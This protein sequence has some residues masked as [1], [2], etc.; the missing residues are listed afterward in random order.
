[1]KR[2]TFITSAAATLACCGSGIKLKANEVGNLPIIFPEA[3]KKGDTIGVIAPGTAVTDPDDIGRA[4]EVLSYFGLKM[5]LGKYVSSGN[6]YKTRPIAQRLDDI[7]SFFEDKNI[8]GIFCIRG[9]YGC[10]RLLDKID[11]ELIRNNPKVFLGYSD[12]T[13]MHLAINK[14]SGLATFH[15]PVM[16]S[17]FTQFTADNMHRAI[18][19]AQPMGMLNNPDFKSNLR[20]SY[21]VR[22]IKGGKASGVLIGGNL[23]LIA[24]L[25]GTP[26]QIEAKDKILFLEDVSEEPFRIDRMLNQL[27]LGG[28]FNEVKGI[29]FGRCADCETK[30]SVWDLSLGEVLD[31]YFSVLD[32]PVIYGLMIGHTQDQ[33]TLPIGVRAELDAD[34]GTLF[35]AEQGVR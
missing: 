8:S 23:S 10:G 35:I 14:F 3:L 18:F 25:M 4:E 9:G 15:G 29:V 11:Y 20:S 24:S 22:K 33:L 12:I 5:K 28:I 16:L 2:R 32:I 19:S 26:Y 34:A 6:G 13:A 17:A 7:H 1:M 27:R 31:S 21:P 30:S